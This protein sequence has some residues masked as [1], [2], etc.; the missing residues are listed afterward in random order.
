MEYSKIQKMIVDGYSSFAGKELKR[1]S[2]GKDFME[3]ITTIHYLE[4]Y[5][6]KRGLVAD[7]GS[8]PGRYAVWL[9]EHGYDV[10]AIDP[11]EKNIDLL[12]D[13]FKGRR[14]S[15]RLKGAYIGFA[16]DLSM[17]GNNSF[18][19]V[20]CLGGPLS[21][22]MR[23]GYR[24]KAVHELV[25]IAKPNARIFASVMGR[26]SLFSGVIRDFS[27]D[28]D[29]EFIMKWAK[30]GNYFGGFG[31]LPYHGFK[32]DELQKLFGRD[33]K[34]LSKAA[35]EGFASYSDYPITKLRRNKR[36]WD[37][38]LKIHFSIS[39]EPETIGVSEHYMVVE[40]KK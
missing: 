25:R 37:K 23:D 32:P 6:P 10:V 2:E 30:T 5:L 40:E 39:E 11:V 28:L 27:S 12:A 14:I 17:L 35:L 29:T 8:G 38:Y 4:R 20:I 1:L 24:K 9:A 15:S 16:E 36:R 13:R 31:F 26:L 3:Y 7:I 21:H 22:V 33:T 19:A 18:D 34:L